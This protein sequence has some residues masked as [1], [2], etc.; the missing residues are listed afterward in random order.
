[1]KKL[2]FLFSLNLV[3]LSSF[4]QKNSLDSK[5]FVLMSEPIKTGISYKEKFG[6]EPPTGYPSEW[7]IYPNGSNNKNVRPLK[8]KNVESLSKKEKDLQSKNIHYQKETIVILLEDTTKLDKITW[9]QEIFRES[10]TVLSGSKKTKCNPFV[11]YTWEYK[12]DYLKIYKVLARNS[13]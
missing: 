10:H 9:D 12:E 11:Y 1:M 13:F 4:G 8:F 3:L 7:I 2:L 6:C 5:V